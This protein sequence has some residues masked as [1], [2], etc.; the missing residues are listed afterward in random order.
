MS[1]AK[2]E[3][4]ERIGRTVAKHRQRVELTQEQVAEALGIGN[5]AVS[6]IERGKV[7]PDVI[8]LLELATLF[9]CDAPVLLTEFSRQPNDQADYLARLLGELNEAD[10]LMVVEVVERLVMGLRQR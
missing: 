1:D 3:W 6:R 4:A 9:Q 10:R 5:E 2:R 8:R 7:V